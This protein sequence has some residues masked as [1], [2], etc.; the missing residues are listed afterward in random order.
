MRVAFLIPHFFIGGGAS[1]MQPM[2]YGSLQPEARV[3]RR[4]MLDRVLYQLHSLF[5]NGHRALDVRPRA[6][7]Q[8]SKLLPAGNPYRMD[9]DIV[10]FTT[11]GAHLLDEL[12]GRQAFHHIETAAEPLFLGFECAR[13]IR[14]NLG[15]YDLYA[16]LEDDIVVRDPLFLHKIKLFNDTFEA[17]K[18][19]LL[20][21]PQRYEET[22]NANDSNLPADVTRV[23]IDYQS[24]DEPAFAG[25]VLSLDFAGTHVRFEPAL[26]PHAGC[27]IL[28]NEQAARMIAHP[29]FLDPNE[30]HKSPLDSAATLFVSRALKVYKPARDSLAFLDVQHGH[31]RVFPLKP[32]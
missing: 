28:N 32:T 8:N 19:G 13:W 11:R 31:P 29:Q 30:P 10:L 27:Y 21:Q 14:D 1:N 22:L 23:Y 7:G 16:Y 24:T 5:G 4:I 26:C 9:Y 6:Q 2:A 12:Q 3:V 25:D 17:G 18:R 20:L 15:T